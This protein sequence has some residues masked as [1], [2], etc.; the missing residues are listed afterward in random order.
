MCRWM[1]PEKPFKQWTVK[2]N[3]SVAF[4]DEKNTKDV[5]MTS[6]GC[7]DKDSKKIK[8][9]LEDVQRMSKGFPKDIL[10]MSKG[11]PEGSKGVLQRKDWGCIIMHTS[12]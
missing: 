12:A 4:F 7:R 5:R 6:T 10:R 1:I 8:I 3:I 11:H 2:N 9:Y